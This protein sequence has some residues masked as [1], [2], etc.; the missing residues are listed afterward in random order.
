[1]KAN[2]NVPYTFFNTT[3][4][5]NARLLLQ[6]VRPSTINVRCTAYW[7]VLVTC[8]QLLFLAH[9]KVYELQNYNPWNTAMYQWHV[10]LIHSSNEVITIFDFHFIEF[11]ANKAVQ[12]TFHPSRSWYQLTDLRLGKSQTC[13]VLPEN[14]IN[15][16]QWPVSH[17]LDP[18]LASPLSTVKF[19]QYL[20]DFA[21]KWG[22]SDLNK[23][24]YYII[25]VFAS[26]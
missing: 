9:L 6:Q 17:D 4:H 23:L 12:R 5:G 1:M 13:R 18:F 25:T 20:G 24:V 22:D 15:Y 16:C 3:K 19:S 7:T 11:E 10:A 14:D 2:G 26:F 8:I 21:G